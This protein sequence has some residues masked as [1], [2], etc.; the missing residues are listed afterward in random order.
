MDAQEKSNS[1]KETVMTCV[2]APRIKGISTTQFIAFT[3]L[4]DLYENR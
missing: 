4:K 3:R 2:E 1:I